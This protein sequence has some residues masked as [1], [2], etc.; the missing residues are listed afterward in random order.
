MRSGYLLKGQTLSDLAGKLGINSEGLV[1]TVADFDRH[2]VRGDDP[3][4]NKGGTA[5]ERAAGDA[6]NMPNPCVAP[7]GKGPFYA[8]R[9]VPGDIGT[10]VGIHV[11][12]MGR[13]LTDGGAKIPG[14]FA[15]GTAT[16]SIMGGTYPGAGAM[17]GPALT[18]GYLA[19]KTIAEEATDKVA[20]APELEEGTVD[21]G[22][23]DR[24]SLS[25][26]R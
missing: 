9:M 16:S 23:V 17:L 10:F 18:F 15:V 22:S 3:Q 20:L 1:K 2:A 13:V 11:D 25:G 21:G 8:I 6:G 24:P 26:P 5:F 12:S 4:F 19:A 14:L 7:L